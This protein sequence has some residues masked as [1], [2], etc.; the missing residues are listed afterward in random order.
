MTYDSRMDRDPRH[1]PVIHDHT[2]ETPD[3]IAAGKVRGTSVYNA[4]GDNLGTIDDLMIGKRDGRVAYAVLS[5]GGFLGI[6]EKYTPLPWHVLTYDA[7]K[8][9]YNIGLTEDQLRNAPAYSRDELS[10]FGSEA[11]DERVTRY[12][13]GIGY[14]PAI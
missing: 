9:G 14:P 1:D 4:A 3:L 2:D 12:Y 13:G 6:G 7:D 11:E 10:A 5:F 8:G